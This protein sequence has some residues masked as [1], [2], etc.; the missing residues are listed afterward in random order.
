MKIKS[1]FYVIVLLLLTN[2]LSAQIIRVDT[3]KM[4]RGTNEVV[5]FSKDAGS[6]TTGIHGPGHDNNVI[7]LGIL[8][9]PSGNIPLYYERKMLPWLGLQGGVGLTTR[10]F[11]ADVVNILF[12]NG[13]DNYNYY[14]QY[15]ERKP[16]VGYYLSAQPKFYF[17]G[18]ATDGFWLSPMLEF[19]RFNFKA[20]MVAENAAAT[21]EQ[22][23]LP[24]TFF[25]EHRN[26][27]DFTVNIGWQWLLDNKV[28]IE[29]SMGAGFRR[30]WEHRL[31]VEGVATI[32]SYNYSSF[33]NNTRDYNGWRPEFNLCLNVGGFF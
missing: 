5:I 20:N 26:D 9:V 18:D 16:L 14:Y 10:D 1:I 7:K 30:F 19:K 4:G 31:E 27:L 12:T 21:N 2:G 29:Y 23:Y 24:N 13:Q 28:A 22:S 3:S 33:S 6:S 8:N 25:S 32:N 17:N 11:V 15:T